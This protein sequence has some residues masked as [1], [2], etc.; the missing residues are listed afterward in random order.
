MRAED[1]VFFITVCCQPRGQNQL[2]HADIASKLFESIF[3][4]HKWGDWWMHSVLFMPDHMHALA[5]FPSEKD[6]RTV[7]TQWKK[8]AARKFSVNWQRDFFDHRLRSDE[9]LRDKEDYIRMNPVRAGLATQ[10]E[11]WPYVWQPPTG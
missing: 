6:V 4:R 2:C 7:V 5:S 8:Y 9:S 1:A 11:D 10:P 3:F